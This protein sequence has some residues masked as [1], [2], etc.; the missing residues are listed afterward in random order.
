ALNTLKTLKA[1]D[2]RGDL[3]LES[4]DQMEDGARV[5]APG[6]APFLTAA[7]MARLGFSRCIMSSPPRGAVPT[8]II[9]RKIERRSCAICRATIPPS[10][11]PRTSQLSNPKPSRKSSACGAIPPT[12]MDT[13]PVDRPTPALSN[14][15]TS[16]PVASGSVTAGSQLSR[17]PVKCWRNSNGRAGPLPKRR[18]AYVSFL[19][20]RNWVGAFVLLA[21]VVIDIIKWYRRREPLQ[22]IR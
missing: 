16:R 11:N 5:A 12:V 13:L 22:E 8:R 15:M 4:G 7:A 20:R 14:K 18:N 10:E 17:V 3:I 2:Q 21:A 19:P 6:S 1:T 9:R